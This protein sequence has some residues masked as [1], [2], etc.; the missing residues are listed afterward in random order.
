MVKIQE[1]QSSEVIGKIIKA[2]LCFTSICVMTTLN[3]HQDLTSAG[4]LRPFLQPINTVAQR[5]LRD[6]SRMPV[7][8]I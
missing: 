8:R 3:I 1:K 5:A 7:Y 4:V 6:S 2:V